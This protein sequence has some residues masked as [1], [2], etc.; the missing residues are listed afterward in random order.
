MPIGRT[1]QYGLRNKHRYDVPLSKTE[2][3]FYAYFTN[4]LHEW[5]LL[6]EYVRNFATFADFKRKLHTSIRPVKNSVFGVSDISGIKKLTMLRLEFSALKDHRFR[7]KFQC[8]SP[9]CVCNTGIKDNAHIFPHCTLFDAFRNDLLGQLSCLP[10]LDLSNISPKSL[11]CLILYGTPTPNESKNRR[12]LE[13][14]TA[15]IKATNRLF[16][17]LATSLLFCFLSIIK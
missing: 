15:Y 4:Y 12:I 10:E 17:T 6:D 1:L 14:S 11:L 9:M 3:S 13:A 2:R 5:N 8:I 16:Y 7:Q